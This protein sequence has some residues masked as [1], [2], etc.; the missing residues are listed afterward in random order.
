MNN[1]YAQIAKRDD[2]K[3]F[4]ILYDVGDPSMYFDDSSLLSSNSNQ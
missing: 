2:G 4:I 3:R 1:L